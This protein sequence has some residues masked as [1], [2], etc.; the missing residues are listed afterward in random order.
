MCNLGQ[1]TKENLVWALLIV[2]S[3]I[4][5]MQTSFSC[6]Q[7]EI[8]PSHTSQKQH[9]VKRGEFCSTIARSVPSKEQCDGIVNFPALLHQ[10]RKVF[11]QGK[12]P[13]S[14]QEGLGT[15]LKLGH[16][17][18]WFSFALLESSFVGWAGTVW[19]RVFF[20]LLVCNKKPLQERRRGTGPGVGM[21]KV[22]AGGC[23]HLAASLFFQCLLWQLHSAR[24]L[25]CWAKHL[26]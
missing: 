24:V 7:N 14:V 25:I 2:I 6:L 4:Y 17:L 18:L 3:G 5:G 13:S 8:I 1:K 23:R 16:R 19:A 15:L 21:E 22:G 12:H 26:F 10:F 20:C 11:Q 9:W